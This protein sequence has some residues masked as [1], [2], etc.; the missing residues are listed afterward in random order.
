MP[1]LIHHIDAIARKKQR[2]VL[3]LTFHLT[4]AGSE[5][6]WNTKS[7]DYH[8]DTTRDLVC[9]WLSEH[10]IAWQ[11]CG[12]VANENMLSSYR[13]QIY[14]D[15]PFDDNDPSYVLVR[16]Y[17]ENPDGTMR[18][19][20]VIFWYLPLEKAMANAHHDEPSFWDEWTKN[21]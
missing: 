3:Y 1:M 10:G 16:D 9:E 11:L 12:Q 4:H 6:C 20:S 15:V 13:G 18:F 8:E 5:E 17:L 21:F 2:D 19:P 14:L 7:Y